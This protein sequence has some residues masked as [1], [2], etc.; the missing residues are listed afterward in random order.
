MKFVVVGA[1]TGLGRCIAIGLAQRGAEV[2][3]LARREDLLLEAAKEAGSGA[4][5]FICDVT[6]PGSC[7]EVVAKAAEAL[8]G[9]DG[10]VYC[11]GVGVLRRIEDL[12]LEDWHKTF[13]TN[14]V[15]A[16]LFTAAALP[17]LKESSGVAIYLSSVSASF[18]AP[19][20]GLASY[21]VTKAAM[22]KLVEAWRAEHPDVGFTRVVVG[23]CAGGEGVA[24]SQFMTGWDTDL[25]GELFPTWM[26]RGLLA[27]TVYR[28]DELV[29]VVDSVLRCGA[30]AAIPTVTVIP[31]QSPAATS[32]SD[33][34][35][36][37]G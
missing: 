6:N 5:V 7:R 10:V 21:T 33:L 27:G 34:G 12:Q 15:G 17:H 25:L 32:I 20:P 37:P 19:W 24:A 16:S 11:P 3:M 18:T 28:P 13:D 29:H 2:V 26:H 35:A 30:S 31:R 23:D 4:H 14:V 9:I 1:S 36:T 8:G 22:D